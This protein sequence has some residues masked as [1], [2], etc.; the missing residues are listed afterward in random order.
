MN[1]RST[2]SC[3]FTLIELLVVISIVS[4]LISILLPA[5]AGARKQAKIMQCMS[6]LRGMGLAW[7][8][9]TNDHDQ[10]F[11][12]SY[13]SLDGHAGSYGIQILRPYYFPNG[14]ENGM[15]W[16]GGTK[17]PNLPVEI[18]PDST[19]ITDCFG[20]TAIS[21]ANRHSQ[22]RLDT[23]RPFEFTKP[24][25]TSFMYDSD[26]Y[27]NPSVWWTYG[28]SDVWGPNFIYSRHGER[29]NVWFLDGHVTTENNQSP[30]LDKNKIFQMHA[31]NNIYW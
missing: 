25:K 23:T 1:K 22:N 18:C 17:Y 28:I 20:Y 19:V 3:G 13:V 29:E 10:W 2:A 26:L 31:F 24:S 4:L 16:N 7:A 11:P 15:W 9:Y 21:R 30:Y 5:L 8:M 27:G 6:N 14:Y 12:P